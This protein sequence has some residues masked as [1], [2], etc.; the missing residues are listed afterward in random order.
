[1]ERVFLHQKLKL[2]LEHSKVVWSAVAQ[3]TAFDVLTKLYRSQLRQT[4][5]ALGS[6]RMEIRWY[7]GFTRQASVERCSYIKSSSWRLSTPSSLECCI[8]A[9]AFDVLT[10]LCRSQLRLINLALG[11]ERMEIAGAAFLRA[12]FGMSVSLHQKL[13]LCA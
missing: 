7:A 9:T 11:S 12:G 6:E 13:K 4:K 8:A 2:A 3:L 1:M 5:F 10:K